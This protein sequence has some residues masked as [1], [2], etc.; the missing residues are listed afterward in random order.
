MEIP[1]TL[2]KMEIPEALV[3]MGIPETRAK[4]FEARDV[5]LRTEL[6]MV[7]LRLAN[8]NLVTNKTQRLCYNESCER[9]VVANLEVLVRNHQQSATDPATLKKD[10]EIYKKRLRASQ[11]LLRESRDEIDR[12]KFL[13]QIYPRDAGG[14]ARFQ[15]MHQQA[16]M[17]RESRMKRQAQLRI[18]ARIEEEKVEEQYKSMLN[19]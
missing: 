9:Y 19:T 18:V 11:S 15:R 16:D 7:V 6:L 1:E 2:V 4:M 8:P 10:L 12:L 13:P 3:K 5:Y 17:R 14:L